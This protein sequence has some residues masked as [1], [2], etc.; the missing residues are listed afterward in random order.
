LDDT[1]MNVAIRGRRTRLEDVV[2]RV[3]QQLGDHDRGII[4]DPRRP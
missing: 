2:D 4:T 3:P 1:W